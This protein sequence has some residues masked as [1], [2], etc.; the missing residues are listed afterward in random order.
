MVDSAIG[1][2]FNHLGVGA[3]C[4]DLPRL[5][6]FNLVSTLNIGTLCVREGRC[7]LPW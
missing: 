7:A 2:I 6:H 5:R 3:D 1:K 4:R